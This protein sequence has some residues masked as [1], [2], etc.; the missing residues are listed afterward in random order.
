MS[1]SINLSLF[2]WSTIALALM[3]VYEP[4]VYAALQFDPAMLSSDGAQ[5]ADLSGFG[6]GG[7]AQLPG[8]YL[9]GIYLNGS[10]VASRH[11]HFKHRDEAGDDV[12]DGTG[13]IACLTLQDLRDLGI[14]TDI[15]SGLRN[16]TDGQCLSPGKYIKGAFSAFDF[17]AQRLNISIPQ[18][19]LQNQARGWISPEHWDNGINAGLLSYQFSG[20]ENRGQYGS[21][22]SQ[23]LNL[24]SGINLGP[25]RLRDNSTWTDSQTPYSHLRRWQH[26][27]TYIQRA[28]IPLRSELT[29]GDSSS[30][31]EVF[32]AFSFRGVQ[33]ATDDS[34]YP[35]SL[36]G[37]AP[38]IRGTAMSNAQVV[39]RQNGNVI[40]QMAVAAGE[41]LIHDLY[42][43]SGGG[44]LEVT[45]TEAG[46][47]IRTFTVPYSSLPVLQRQGHVRYA[48][49]AGHYRNGSDLY[50]EP[51]FAQ[52]TVQW[53]LSHGITVYGGAQMAEHYQSASLGAGVNAGRLGA[54]SADVTQA[55]SGLADGTTH[56]GQ[57]VR[58]LYGRSLVS[59]GTTVQLAGYRYSTQ[60]FHTLGETAMKSMSGWLHDTRDVDAA[61][62]PIARQWTQYYNLHDSRRERIELNISQSLGNK[63]SLYANGS[64]QTYWHR[65]VATDSLQVGISSTYRQISWTLSYGY[66]R[67]SDQPRP[68]RTYYLSLSVPF[69]VFLSHDSGHN[70]RANYSTRRDADG[71]MTQQG[72]FTG[73]ALRENNL[74][75]GVSQ[76]YSRMNGNSGDLNMAWQGT[77]G[78]LYAGYG[79]AADYR[80]V[81]YGVSGG[82]IAHSGGLT[83]GQ[84]L[85]TTNILVAAPGATGVPL[86][87]G[88]GIHTDWR[89]YTLMPYTSSYRD[90]RVAL[91]VSHLDDH[92]DLDN[93]VAHVVPTLGAVVRADFAAHRGARIM[94][95]LR[96]AGKPLPFGS[97]VVSE[98]DGHESLVADGGVAYLTGLPPAGILKAKWGR[99]ADQQC[100]VHYHISAE[101]QRQPLARMEGE[102]L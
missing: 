32:D 54:L 78:N 70:I 31:S 23:F 67:V 7:G 5:V 50:G 88:T 55:K 87:N 85:G 40:Y 69:S 20:S 102:C 61:G 68:D 17:P 89:G 49:T 45:V 35:D 18:V 28:I 93:A 83:L 76:S 56:D 84:S 91:D 30:G 43:V 3:V 24:T 95:A 38:E 63:G 96:H 65:N 60:G 72:G 42:P 74:S 15:Y 14:N 57:S 12:R 81:R 101:V 34:M 97:T 66:S 13:L 8:D 22:S 19:A 98:A 64:H 71:T 82:I 75:W 47:S 1:Y 2:K 86:E 39:V 90:N 99:N 4:M 9:I 48:L 62:R 46:G 92:T 73:T 80:Q 58:F 59:T 10:P 11:M 52:G 37:F 53:G 41:F 77:Y 29:A 79:Y 6:L 44:D 100:T 16:A 51:A 21:S 25:W 33:L 94:M 26:L 27:S 36:R